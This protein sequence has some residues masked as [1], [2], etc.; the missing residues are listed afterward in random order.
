MDRFLG[1]EEA[2]SQEAAT[3]RMGECS[4]EFLRWSFRIEERYWV[5]VKFYVFN[6]YNPNIPSLI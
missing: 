6:K 2:K 3:R 5:L 1:S 4:K